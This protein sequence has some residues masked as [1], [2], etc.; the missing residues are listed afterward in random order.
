MEDSFNA[1]LFEQIVLDNIDSGLEVE[2]PVDSDKAVDGF[3]SDNT[4]PFAQEEFGQVGPILTGYP[5]NQRCRFCLHGLIVQT[6]D[7]ELSQVTTM[8]ARIGIEVPS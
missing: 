3:R 1:V 8:Q 4:V 2:G 5:R 7:S 6:P